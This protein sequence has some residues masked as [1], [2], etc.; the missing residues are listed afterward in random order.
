MQEPDFVRI[1]IKRLNRMH[2]R[3]MITGSVACILYGEPRL[4]H[5]ID[6][7]L[8]LNPEIAERLRELFPL[9]AVLLSTFRDPQN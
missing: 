9:E 4:T 3:Y 5:D 2:T 1:F 6:L 8:E 7:I